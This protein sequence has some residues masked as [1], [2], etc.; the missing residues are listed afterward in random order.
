MPSYLLTLA[1]PLPCFWSQRPSSSRDDDDDDEDEPEA[2]SSTTS[3][4]TTPS[5]PYL[6]LLCNGQGVPYDM[7]LASVRAYLWKKPSEDLVFHF[8]RLDP[9]NPAPMPTITPPTNNC[10]ELVWML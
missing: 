8:R 6:E 10:I 2:S 1:L 3:S 4:S 5:Q 9:K 7:N